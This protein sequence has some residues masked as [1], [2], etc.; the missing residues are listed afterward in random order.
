MVFVY[1][2]AIFSV[3]HGEYYKKFE[4][5]SD[6]SQKYTR[7]QTREKREADRAVVHRNKP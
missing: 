4:F 5:S 3:E 2:R 6:T 7:S 1:N